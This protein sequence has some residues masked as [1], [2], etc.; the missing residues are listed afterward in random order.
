MNYSKP[1][2]RLLGNALAVIENSTPPHQKTA[3]QTDASNTDNPAY[4]LDE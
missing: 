2:I 4:D 3:D 1:E